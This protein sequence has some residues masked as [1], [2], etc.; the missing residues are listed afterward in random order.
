LGATNVIM[1]NGLGYAS[2]FNNA[3]KWLPTDTL[4]TPQIGIGWHPYQAGSTGYPTSLD[5]G[6][7]T[8]FVL[9]YPEAYISGA[10]SYTVN[11][12]GYT[13]PGRP[14]PVVASET[15]AS[16]GSGQANPSTYMQAMTKWADGG[17]DPTTGASFV[18]TYGLMPWAWYYCGTN[19]ADT[20]GNFYLN[21]YTAGVTIQG[22]S[23]ATNQ[24]GFPINTGTIIVTNANGNTITPGAVITSGSTDLKPVICDQISGTPGGAGTYVYSTNTA[25]GSVGTPVTFTIEY[26]VPCNGGGNTLNAWTTA[27]A[28]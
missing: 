27:H 26:Q 10:S 1:C 19:S 5:T 6:A 28:Q 18:G 7:G 13:G 3:Y 16:G 24:T 21:Y 14:I 22:Y 23:T 4:G 11:G 17:T 25:Q 15:G 20:G 9:Q 12:T 8:A 2:T